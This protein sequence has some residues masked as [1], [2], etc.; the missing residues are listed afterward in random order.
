MRDSET[1]T[2][3]TVAYQPGQTLVEIATHWRISLIKRSLPHTCMTFVKRRC[4]QNR[5]KTKLTQFD[6]IRSLSSTFRVSFVVL[7]SRV[8]VFHFDFDQPESGFAL[9]TL[10]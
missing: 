4:N 1:Q 8:V 6:V 10:R 7:E 2:C 9:G 3:T 5:N